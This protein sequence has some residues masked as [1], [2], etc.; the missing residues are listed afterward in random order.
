MRNKIILCLVILCT[1]IQSIAQLNID[2]EYRPRFELRHGYR[3]AALV[4]NPVIG[5]ISQ[6]SRLNLT[7][8]TPAMRIVFSPQD[9]RIWGDEQLASSTGV[10]GDDASLSL[11]HAYAEIQTGNFGY[12]SVGRQPLVYDNQRLL[13]ERNWNQNG[14]AYDAV[15]FNGH[16]NNWDLHVGASWNSNADLT[17]NCYPPERIKS[18]NFLWLNHTFSDQLNASLLHIASGK[19]QTDTSSQLF[20]RQTSGIYVNYLKD[21]LSFLANVYYQYG[22]N[23][24]NDDINAWLADVKLSYRFG[25]L[26]PGLGLSYLS[27]DSNPVSGDDKLFD[28]L[29]GARH[30]F[31]GH[32]DFFRNIPSNTNY[33]GLEDYYLFVGY[34]LSKTIS[35]KDTWHYFR[36]ANTNNLTPNKK[37][38]GMENELS[39]N[40]KINDFTE[41]ETSWLIY[42]PTESFQTMKGYQSDKYPQ[43]V[44]LE[45]TINPTLFTQQN[46]D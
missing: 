3:N 5:C 37:D 39:I 21:Q 22:K 33:G 27:G 19:T 1:S 10:Y 8:L 20:F 31:F 34:K 7:Y 25:K 4:D 12:V 14:L 35:I 2:L 40:W 36:L 45:L 30:R 9:V 16:L 29:Y 23:K 15:V 17:D 38:L 46:D 24:Q 18:L 43:F 6:R 13:A 11:F 32:M 44:Y 26:K 28:V 42:N 41:L